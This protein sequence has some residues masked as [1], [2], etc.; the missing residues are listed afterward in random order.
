MVTLDPVDF[1]ASPDGRSLATKS[2]QAA[3]DQ[4]AAQG[5]GVVCLP[6]GQFL[7]GTVYMKSGVSLELAEH[8]TLLGSTHLADYPVTVP[9]FRSYADMY[10][11][12]SLIY[13]ENLS[14]IGIQGKGTIDG[15][16]AAFSGPYKVRPYG[17]RFVTCTD[18]R[19]EGVTLRNSPMW[20]QHYLACERVTIRGITVWNHAN[21]NNDMIDV[22]GCRDVV[23]ADCIGDSDDDGIT[24]KSS[25]TRPCENV[26]VTNCTVSSHCS[27]IK[28]G[29]ES[30]GG[31]KNISISKCTVRPSQDRDPIN[32]CPEG[33]AGIALEIVDGGTMDG[34]TISDVQMTDS[35]APLFIRL[36]HRARLFEQGQSEPGVGILRNVTISNVQ[37]FGAD[38][39]GCVIAGLENHAIEN[40]ALKDIEFTFAGG[41]KQADVTRR[42]SERARDYP[43]S[44]MF[45]KQVTGPNVEGPMSPRTFRLRGKT[46]HFGRLPAYGIYF[47]HVKG[48]NIQNVRLTTVAADER[49]A[50]G[51]ENV[52]EM[53]IDGEQMDDCGELPDGVGRIIAEPGSDL[54]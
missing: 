35:V 32:G 40:V 37:A 17:L 39:M 19:V 20:M 26:T 16:G 43:E 44:S 41:G 51:F 7:A 18:V 8:C 53:S 54:D 49:P 42:F 50:I 47:W 52:N 24:L 25:C 27:A 29:T 38:G 3:I 46:Y 30:N 33:W 21:K 4:C 13:A 15:Q 14:H 36:G 9:A 5:G 34:V 23:I 2:I 48:V 10:T 28:C 31:F 1:G 22:D 11:E 12:R 45:T 6:A